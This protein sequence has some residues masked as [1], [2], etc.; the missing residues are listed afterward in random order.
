MLM[1]IDG[2]VLDPV[3]FGLHVGYTDIVLKKKQKCCIRLILFDVAFV[4]VF[5]KTS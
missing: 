1:T 2:V 5:S 3:S 4:V